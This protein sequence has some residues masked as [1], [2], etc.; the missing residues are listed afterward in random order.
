M[1]I[2]FRSVHPYYNAARPLQ[3]NW[4]LSLGFVSKLLTVLYHNWSLRCLGILLPSSAQLLR[5]P[6]GSAGDVSGS[7]L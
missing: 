4:R 1:Y 7:C 5:V 2:L 6:S 3:R